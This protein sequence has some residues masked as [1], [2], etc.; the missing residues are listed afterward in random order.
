MAYLYALVYVG[1][2]ECGGYSHLLGLFD[3][4]KRAHLA[5][6]ENKASDQKLDYSSGGSSRV[7]VQRIAM[8]QLNMLLRS[9]PE[10]TMMG[11]HPVD[12]EH[13]FAPWS[14]E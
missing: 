7:F 14:A 5:L 6:I 1:C 4:E 11:T 12:T 10:V 2:L 9:G 13:C 8:H 3:D